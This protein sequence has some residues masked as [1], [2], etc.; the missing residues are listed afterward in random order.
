MTETMN[1]RAVPT[2]ALAMVLALA[3]GGPARA[4]SQDEGEW[5]LQVEALFMEVY[6][7]DQ[8]VLTIHERDF[9]P[10]PQVENKTAVNIE[11]DSGLGYRGELQYLRNQWGWGVDFFWFN[12]SQAT[13]NRSAAAGGAFDEVGFEVADR[14]FT[15]TDPSQTV[16]YNVLEDNDLAVWT[17]DFYAIRTLAEKP[18]SRI[19]LQF[20]IRSGDFDNDYR[21]VVGIENGGGHRIDAS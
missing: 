15:S 21:A 8:H 5:T 10:I 3:L 20:G 13:P 18:Q 12:T 9:D 1:A 4:Q 7:H 16:F 19:D 11:T 2:I 17:L 6:G 14:T